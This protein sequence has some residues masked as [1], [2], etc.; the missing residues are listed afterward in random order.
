MLFIK[1]KIERN[2][3]AVPPLCVILTLRI[4]GKSSGCRGNRWPMAATPITNLGSHSPHDRPR[5]SR[6]R[7]IARRQL[8]G[9]LGAPWGRCRRS[10]AELERIWPVRVNFLSQSEKSDCGLSVRKIGGGEGTRII[11]LFRKRHCYHRWEKIADEGQ[12]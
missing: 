11:Q 9:H 6:R 8:G 1:A 2:D 3:P 5:R 12:L 10:G 4:L 7:I